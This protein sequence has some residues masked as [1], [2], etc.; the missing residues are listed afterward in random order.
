[1]KQTILLLAVIAALSSCNGKKQPIADAHFIDSL[2]KNYTV[3]AAVKANAEEMQFWKSRISASNPGITNESKYA[4]ALAMRFH[5]LGNIHDLLASDSVLLGI[6][7]IYGHKEAGPILSLTRHSILQHRFMQAAAYFE[8]ARKIGLKNYDLYCTQFDVNFELGRY[9]FAE[10]DLVPLKPGNDYAYQFRNSKLAHYKGDIGMATE[11][12]QKAVELSG[13][14]KYLKQAALSNVADLWLHDGKMQKAYDA[15]R[16]AIRQDASDLHS[17]MGIGVIAMVHDKNDTLARRIFE[18]VKGRTLLAD[19]LFKLVQLA[20]ATGDSLSALNYARAFEKQVTDTV[21]GNMYN[22]YLVELYTGVLHEPAKAEAIA[23]R[24][25]DNRNTPQTRA[26]YSW[27]L[28]ANGKREEAY[29]NFKQFVSGKPL[30][31]LELYWMGK[32]M[33]ELGKGYNAQEFFDAAYRN[34]FDLGPVMMADLERERE[35]Y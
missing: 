10:T 14:D 3:P 33:Q 31:G 29:R 26:W 20:Q 8:Q 21:Y 17:I 1:M 16:A 6:D 11:A 12:M 22:K 9:L 13:S 19:P 15:Y 5:L 4:A 25:L 30:E 7:S 34:R 28:F 23:M 2:I 35:N 24:E 27:A 18:F 32:M